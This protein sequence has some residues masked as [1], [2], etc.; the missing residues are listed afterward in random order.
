MLDLLILGAGPA[1][2]TAAIYAA[3]S[4][5]DTLVL[6]KETAGGQIVSTGQVDNYP[7]LPG[8][9]GLVL[10]ERLRKHAEQLGTSFRAAEAVRLEDCGTYKKTVLADGECL[11]ARSV[12]AATGAAPRLLGVPGE[13]RLRGSGVSYCAMCDGAFYRGKRVCVIGGG[14]TAVE[15]ALQLA[16]QAA[17]VVLIH[18]RD[19]LRAQKAHAAQLLRLE[20]VSV[21]WNT[22]VTEI[23]GDGAV[24]GVRL[25]ALPDGN[26][27]L[28][29][30]EGVFIAVGMQPETACL[31]PLGVVG[32]DGCVQA[33][34]D[35][36]TAVPGLFAAGDV[37]RK[38][39]RQVVTA[40]ADGA[41]AVRAAQ[42]YLETL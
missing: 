21:R 14:D 5:L 1:G 8:V 2:L 10:A 18:R 34:E 17:E 27:E 26:E 22:V 41:S 3:R 24:S 42:A 33:G 13:E 6:E 39:V 16:R 15:D 28:L 31:E 12:I 23:C 29:P 37:R 20:N 38:P 32:E 25:R 4:Q 7:G 30:V 40:A 36:R 19:R 9:Q 11:S 35:C